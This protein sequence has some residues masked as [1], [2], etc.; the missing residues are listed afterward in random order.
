MLHHQ[1]H[2]RIRI[3]DELAGEQPVG[4][5]AGGVD[6]RPSVD[7]RLKRLLRRDEGGSPLNDVL[8]GEGDTPLAWTRTC[9]RTSRPAGSGLDGLLAARCRRHADD[10]E[11]AERGLPIFG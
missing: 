6:V 11:F 2:C 7:G 1:A 9:P 4:H 10:G 8:A 3:E 5:T